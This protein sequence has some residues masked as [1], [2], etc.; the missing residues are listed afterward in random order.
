MMQFLHS[1]SIVEQAVAADGPVNEDLAVNPLSV[2]LVVLRPLN[3]TGTL[4]NFASYLNVCGAI[5]SLGI[6]FRGESIVRMSGRDLAALAY[7]RHGIIFPQAT[8]AD[9]DD[10]RRAVVLPVLL[11]RFAYD[12]ESCFP[13]SR[14]GELVLELDFDLADTGYDAMRFSVE[15]IELLD[16]K[17]KEYERRVVTTQTLAATGDNDVD[18]PTGN[19]YRG[20]LAFGTT[21][22]SGAAPA[23][24]LGRLSTRLDNREVNYASTDFEVAHGT[25]ALWGRMPPRMD[26]HQHRV[27]ATQADAEELTTLPH[28]VGS[29]GWQNYAFLD[30]DPTRDDKF[31]VETK[32][33][34]RLNV[35]MNAEAANLVRVIGIEVVKT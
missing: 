22:F 14:R 29:G 17:P 35:R 27:D 15:T 31:S 3:D 25:P 34:S 2:I 24:T 19:L 13:A 7:F 32:N 21:G 4:L 6:I 16:A 10:D 1:V 30:F 5:N 26:E 28:N 11:G 9:T 12:T 23:P 20:A 33:A 18:L 8:H